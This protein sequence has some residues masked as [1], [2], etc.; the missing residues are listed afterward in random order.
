MVVIG[1]HDLDLM[2]A[3]VPIEGTVG[4]WRSWCWPAMSVTSAIPRRLRP[5][6]AEP[7]PREPITGRHLPLLKPSP[8]PPRNLPLAD[9]TAD[10]GCSEGRGR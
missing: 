3:D 2:L 7:P 8:L 10:E 4:A 5:R 6:S 1:D 9:S